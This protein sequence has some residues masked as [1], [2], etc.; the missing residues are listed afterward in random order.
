MSFMKF[1]HLSVATLCAI[2][3]L[4]SCS[5]DG[6]NG[7][8]GV[9]G[10][11][12]LTKTTKIGAGSNCTYGGTKI[13]A[14]IDANNNGTLEDTEVTTTQTQYVCDGAGAV[15]SN[16]ID[17][18]VSTNSAPYPGEENYGYYQQLA[19]SAI[20][21]D[22]VNKGVILMYYKNKGGYIIPVDR[23][24]VSPIADTDASGNKFEV[25][26]GYIFKQNYLAFLANDDTYTTL[27][28]VSQMNAN[29]SAV[30]YVIIPGNTAGRSV[31]ELQKL[32]YSEVAKLYNIAD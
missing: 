18:N 24:D 26:V 17:I 5:K 4:A 25:A 8:D 30:R 9:D 19:S 23:E 16:W 31:A 15:Y 27:N 32:P 10:K 1:K 14:G 29:G 21:A 7:L 22:V 12:M 20:T 28:D 11:T 13:E 3:V 6:K 2:V